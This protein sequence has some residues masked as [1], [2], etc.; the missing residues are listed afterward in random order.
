M[1]SL[2][3]ASYFSELADPV[4]LH[5]PGMLI[6]L[7][8]SDSAQPAA[9]IRNS[10][11]QLTALSSHRY[12]IGL[13]PHP[14]QFL[15][16]WGFK[17]LVG[18]GGSNSHPIRRVHFCLSTTSPVRN[19]YPSS[20]TARPQTRTGQPLVIDD[21]RQQFKCPRGHFQILSGGIADES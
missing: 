7:V 16:L 17:E 13:E 8:L 1:S 2:P 19:Y 6:E 5:P 10:C 21:Q 12:F 11:W 9:E 20:H 4:A 3:L 14:R 18:A 15:E